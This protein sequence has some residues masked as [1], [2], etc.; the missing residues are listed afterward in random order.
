M[1]EILIL[2]SIINSRIKNSIVKGNYFYVKLKYSKYYIEFL[3]KIGLVIE[4]K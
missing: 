1:N 3:S 4:F 2:E